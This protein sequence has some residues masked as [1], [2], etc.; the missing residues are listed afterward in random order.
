LASLSN[1]SEVNPQCDTG[2]HSWDY[3]CCNQ[4]PDNNGCSGHGDCLCNQTCSCNT[5]GN[6]TYTNS[7]C[8]CQCTLNNGQICSGHGTCDC[9]GGCV[10]DLNYNG[11]LCDCQ[12]CIGNCFGNG[13]CDCENN[14]HCFAGFDPGTSCFCPLECQKDSTGNQCSGNG[15]CVCGVCNC[16]E[17]YSGAICDCKDA[18]FC[19][20]QVF[21][22]ECSGHGTCDCNANCTCDFGW[23][24]L[25]CNTPVPCDGDACN[26]CSASTDPTIIS[27]PFCLWC[28]ITQTC[29]HSGS[30]LAV[31]VLNSSA[32]P[33]TPISN[34]FKNASDACPILN[35]P[36]NEEQRNDN[37][38]IIPI[39]AIVAAAVVVLIAVIA[40][41]AFAL[42]AKKDSG[43]LESEAF[44]SGDSSMA[45][46][47]PLYQPDTQMSVNKLYSEG[48]DKK[49]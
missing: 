24:G 40:G 32:T 4:C 28:P 25:D 7:N 43:L 1:P 48:G 21:E 27:K 19:P 29:Q 8:S 33:S 45:I 14:C 12:L 20:T 2:T 44:L 46:K 15:K 9:N 38:S 31:C 11:T 18:S 5:T 41:I 16:L 49:E 23:S 13:N 17:G 10:C 36:I 22:N 39:A 30:A 34:I 35:V 37:P 3:D 6:T 47:S 26:N 42:S